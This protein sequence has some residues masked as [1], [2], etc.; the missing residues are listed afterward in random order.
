MLNKEDFS[1]RLK[2]ILNKYEITASS[3][4]DSI[5]VP[6]SSIS[7]LLSGRNN[8]SLD[9]VLKLLSNYP[10]VSFDWLVRGKGSIDEFISNEDSINKTPNLFNQES[11]KKNKI[12]HTSLKNTETNQNRNPLKREIEKILILYKDGSFKDYTK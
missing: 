8:P 10:G 11:I 3:F 6:R 4:A 5:G 9:F 7:H 12:E 2:L 1:K